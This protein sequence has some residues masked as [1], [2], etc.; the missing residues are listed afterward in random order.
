[1]PILVSNHRQLS[2]VKQIAKEMNVDIPEPILCYEARKKVL[3]NRRGLIIDDLD[4]M[5]SFMFGDD[6][7][8]AT[9]ENCEKYII[10]KGE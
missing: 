7:H 8:Y 3:G 4:Y 9:M 2:L 10:K 1:M 5:L 6:V